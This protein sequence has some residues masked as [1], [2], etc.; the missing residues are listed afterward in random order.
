MGN[1]IGYLL[2]G[3]AAV[4]ALL[5]AWGVANVVGSRRRR[6]ERVFLE[7]TV[8]GVPFFAKPNRYGPF[9]GHDEAH[10]WERRF[11]DALRASHPALEERARFSYC[12]ERSVME[13]PEEVVAE[14]AHWNTAFRP[15]ARSAPPAA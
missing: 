14:I 1:I 7:L 6:W 13:R 9:A 10:A 3:L 8:E 12:W 5:I 2:I 15:E 4:V 11:R